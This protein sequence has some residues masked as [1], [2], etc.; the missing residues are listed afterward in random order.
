MKYGIMSKIP[1]GLT[2]FGVFRDCWIIDIVWVIRS[3]LLVRTYVVIY[4]TNV[5][6]S[7]T[8]RPLTDSISYSM[9]STINVYLKV[10]DV[11][12]FLKYSLSNTWTYKTVFG[13]LYNNTRHKPLWTGRP[14]LS[15]PINTPSPLR[16]F[17]TKSAPQ[18][19]YSP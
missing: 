7:P 16:P 13:P 2:C 15:G 9:N 5:R 4:S 8:R 17:H 3:C 14:L 19:L 6:W 12:Y 18:P 11:R 10:A 1:I